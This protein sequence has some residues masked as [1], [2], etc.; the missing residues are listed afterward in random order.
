MKTN[1]KNA[2]TNQLTKMAQKKQVNRKWNST[3]FFQIGLIV[4]MIAVGLA[5]ELVK[6]ETIKHSPR[7]LSDP[8]DVVF[9]MHDFVIEKPI[10][11][12][13]KTVVSQPKQLRDLSI[14]VPVK[15]NAAIVE[16]NITPQDQVIKVDPDARLTLEKP[17]EKPPVKSTMINVEVI[18]VFP[19]CEGITDRQESI[20]CLTQKL[21]AFI[22]RKFDTEIASRENLKGRQRIFCTFTINAN[23][24][25]V[26][27]QA[28]A[29]S[30]RLVQEAQRVLGKVP[31]LTPAKQGLDNVAVDFSIPIVFE[32]ND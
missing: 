16:T 7:M 1:T 2:R 20:R 27:V 10:A 13:Q 30:S 14:L 18:P 31:G 4:S 25:I 11:K 21:H 15:D 23:G 9:T 32:V 5:V 17:A 12:V 8:I 19:G 28:R 26:N 3:V 24:N 29:K 6:F 22:G